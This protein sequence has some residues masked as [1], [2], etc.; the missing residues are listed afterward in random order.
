LRILFPAGRSVRPTGP[1]ADFERPGVSSLRPGVTTAQSGRVVRWV[2]PSGRLRSRPESAAVWSWHVPKSAPWL[3]G[4]GGNEPHWVSIV[5]LWEWPRSCPRH[6]TLRIFA[7]RQHRGGHF[8]MAARPAQGCI[9]V[10]SIKRFGLAQGSQVRHRVRSSGSRTVPGG[11]WALLTREPPHPRS[12]SIRMI[13]G[14]MFCCLSV[15]I[16]VRVCT[17]LSSFYVA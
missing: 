10:V 7:G 3:V 9:H 11:G 1:Q 8:A 5:V 13:T 15:P 6:V 17:P 12:S 16:T 14:R 4:R 2:E